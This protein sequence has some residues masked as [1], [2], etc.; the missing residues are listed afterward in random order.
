MD[1]NYHDILFYDSPPWSIDNQN[2]GNQDPVLS[3]SLP[4]TYSPVEVLVSYLHLELSSYGDSLL[5]MYDSIYV[6]PHDQ[7]RHLN[8]RFHLSNT[9]IFPQQGVYISI[10]TWDLGLCV[11]S[12]DNIHVATNLSIWNIVSLDCFNTCFNS[13]TW[14]PSL[15]LYIFMESIEGNAFLRGV[16]CYDPPYGI[17]GGPKARQCNNSGG[18]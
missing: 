13:H 7:V 14:D 6:D 3:I 15:W 9:L 16:E 1:N 12:L 2:E 5:D 8:H 11:I 4:L 18:H 17:N 10:W